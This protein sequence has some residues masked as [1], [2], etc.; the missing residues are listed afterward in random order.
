MIP[1]FLWLHSSWLEV[2]MI[3]IR[4][5]LLF[6]LCLQP[7]LQCCPNQLLKWSFFTCRHANLKTLFVRFLT[8]SRSGPQKLCWLQEPTENWPILLMTHPH[9]WQR[10]RFFLVCW[11]QEPNCDKGNFIIIAWFIFYQLL[12]SPCMVLLPCFSIFWREVASKNNNGDQQPL[13]MPAMLWIQTHQPW[14][15]FV[16]HQSLTT[17]VVYMLVPLSKSTLL[18]DEELQ[19]MTE[20]LQSISKWLSWDIRSTKPLYAEYTLGGN[21]RGIYV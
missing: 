1:L 11:H 14:A 9:S 12:T 2:L 13:E 20:T 5:R 18:P 3:F 17:T 15:R 16:I 7:W 8:E 19:Y 21:L 10:A 4:S 6:W